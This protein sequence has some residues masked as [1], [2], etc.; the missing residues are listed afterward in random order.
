MSL[1]ATMRGERNTPHSRAQAKQAHWHTHTHIPYRLKCLP[2]T[3]RPAFMT[4]HTHTHTHTH[5]LQ[6]QTPAKHTQASI[7]DL[8]HTHTHTHRRG[9]LPSAGKQSVISN[10]NIRV[11]EFSAC[12]DSTHEYSQNRNNNH[13]YIN[14]HLTLISLCQQQQLQTLTIDSLH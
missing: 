6:A 7:H 9:T 12:T 2:N 1:C 8:T 13:T 11:T 3:L 5:T 4:S 14:L 10:P